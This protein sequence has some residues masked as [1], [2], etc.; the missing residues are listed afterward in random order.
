MLP[1]TLERIYNLNTGVIGRNENRHERPHK[2]AML[3]AV[4]DLIATGEAKQQHIEW[5]RA[6]RQRFTVYFEIVRTPLDKNTPEN[7]FY[8]LGSEELRRSKAY[9]HRSSPKGKVRLCR[10]MDARRRGIP[11][12]PAATAETEGSAKFRNAGKVF[13]IISV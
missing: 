7:P 11:F 2:P 3:L 10:S 13:I 8:Y 12:F 4:L 1:E 6:L 9:L 5:G